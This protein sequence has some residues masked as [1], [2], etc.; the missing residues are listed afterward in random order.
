MSKIYN[1]KYN[2]ILFTDYKK[3]EKHKDLASIYFDWWKNGMT[4]LIL[5]IN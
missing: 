2:I 5:I 4:M 1:F 3:S